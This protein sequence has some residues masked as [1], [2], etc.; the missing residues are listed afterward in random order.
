M[1]ITGI[2]ENHNPTSLQQYCEPGAKIPEDLTHCGT[3]QNR[4]GTKL[5]PDHFEQHSEKRPKHLCS[6]DKFCSFHGDCCK[7]FQTSCPEELTKFKDIS[8]QYPLNH[9][10]SDFI[11]EKCNAIGDKTFQN[12]LIH[13]CLDGSECDFGSDVHFGIN[14]FL[15]MYDIHRG[16]HYISEKCAMCNAATDV[17]SWNAIVDCLKHSSKSAIHSEY[18]LSKKWI[19]TAKDTTGLFLICKKTKVLFSPFGETRPCVKNIKSTC[20]PSCQN[21]NLVD[22]CEKQPL[23][24]TNLKF[25]LEGYRNEYCAVCNGQEP[26]D[27]VDSIRCTMYNTMVGPSIDGDVGLPGPPGMKGI[28]GPPGPPG[29]PGSANM[30]PQGLKGY[31]GILIKGPKGESSVPRIQGSTLLKRSLTNISGQKQEMYTNENVFNDKQ[32]F[33]NHVIV[34]SNGQFASCKEGLKGIPG[35]KGVM[36]PPGPSGPPGP[37]GEPGPITSGLPGPPGLPG[38]PVIGLPG[39]PGEI[40]EGLRCTEDN[41]EERPEPPGLPGIQVTGPPE[42]PGEIDEGLNC[43]EKNMEKQPESPTEIDNTENDLKQIP[44]DMCVYWIQ[45]KK[46][47]IGIKGQKG[48]KGDVGQRGS[49]GPPGPAGPSGLSRAGS[50]GPRGPPGLSIVGQRG[51]SG[52]KHCPDGKMLKTQN[53]KVGKQCN[54]NQI[55][56]LSDDGKQ[57]TCRLGYEIISYNMSATQQNFQ[58]TDCIPKLNTISATVTVTL[59]NLSD[60]TLHILNEK[61]YQ[62]KFDLAHF[63]DLFLIQVIKFNNIVPHTFKTTTNIG[64]IQQGLITG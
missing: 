52:A 62:M 43:T 41:M 50:S 47:P 27:S 1:S 37:P 6:C 18:L 45:N 8:K 59:R 31:S 20:R 63:M 33:D 16:V 26:W 28:A 5:N 48:D 10:P 25:H 17:K 64:E 11:C 19:V 2:Q 58:E 32:H 22:L 12:L 54:S 57:C 9:N 24:L 44:N 53:Y 42:E 56:T 46:G 49:A 23:S 35:L 55:L 36:E 3:C 14:M 29:P 39:E 13:T 4:C 38:I 61:L 60:R 21:K 30:G 40:Y 15:P 34:K 7:D 51:P